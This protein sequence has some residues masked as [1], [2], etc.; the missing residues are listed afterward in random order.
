MLAHLIWVN[1]FCFYF[2]FNIY[3]GCFPCDILLLWCILLLKKYS[4]KLLLYFSY[5]SFFIFHGDCQVQIGVESKQIY[6]ENLDRLSVFVQLQQTWQ[7]IVD[8]HIY[9]CI[10][11]VQLHQA[12]HSL[13]R[14]RAVGTLQSLNAL[15]KVACRHNQHISIWVSCSFYV[16]D[17]QSVVVAAVAL[18]LFI[19]VVVCAHT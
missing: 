3:F 12:W 15:C 11:L 17:M 10:V 16:C 19:V 5:R 8:A 14:V 9:V 7:S 2:G 6:C 13:D 4:Y 18:F 1:E